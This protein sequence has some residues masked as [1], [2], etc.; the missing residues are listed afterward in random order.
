MPQELHRPNRRTHADW[1]K[2]RKATSRRD[3]WGDY[4]CAVISRRHNRAF[5]G[6]VRQS[7]ERQ[8]RWSSA[9]QGA[10]EREATGD[11][12][13]G[14]RSAVGIGYGQEILIEDRKS[15]SRT[16]RSWSA[17]TKSASRRS[18]ARPSDVIRIRCP[19]NGNW[20][21]FHPGIHQGCADEKRRRYL[22]STGCIGRS[23][24]ND[25]HHFANPERFVYHNF[26]KCARLRK[27]IWREMASSP[28]KSIQSTIIPNLQEILFYES[29]LAHLVEGH[30]EFL[31]PSLHRAIESAVS[32]TATSVHV[33]STSPS[34]V[35]F[36]DSNTTNRRGQ[37]LRVPV[38][39]LGNST[40]SIKTAYFASSKS[41][42]VEIWRKG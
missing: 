3:R 36:V 12:Q 39:L 42:D 15:S 22:A 5:E 6:A 25:C 29:A 33:S 10:H 16:I 23:H 27:R 24:C 28:F 40:G 2:R 13:E 20:K 9:S 8:S 4:G 34:S 38:K 7:A 35:I 19:N 30:P 18:K 14:R 17:S 21:R 31:L 11:R 32:I 41:P 37:P 26:R 1:P